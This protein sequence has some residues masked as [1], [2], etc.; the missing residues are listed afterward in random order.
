MLRK[1]NYGLKK[2]GDFLELHDLADCKI[3]RKNNDFLQV[4]REKEEL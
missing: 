2:V 1:W 3:A 4:V